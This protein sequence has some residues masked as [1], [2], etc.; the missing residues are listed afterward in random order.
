MRIIVFTC[1]YP[2]RMNPRA[3]RVEKFVKLN[4]KEYDILVVTSK[5]KGFN[6]KGPNVI[7]CG[8]A[9]NLDDTFKSSIKKYKFIRLLHKAFWPDDQLL[10][11]FYFLINY[12]FR[13][14]KKN[15]LILTVSNP[16]SSHMIGWFLKKICRHKWIADIG[17]IYFGNQHHSMLSKWYER[18]ILNSTDHIVVNAEILRNHFLK[19]YP[20]ASEK[21]TVIPNGVHIDA[22]KINKTKSDTIRLSYIGNTYQDIREA[23]QELELLLK[24]ISSNKSHKYQIQLFGRQYFKVIEWCEQLHGLIN[25]SYCKNEEE[26]I[27][28]YSNTD[29]LINFANKN[30]EGLPS[31]LEEYVASGLPIINFQ[32]TEQD[33]SCLFLHSN[34]SIAYY[35]NLNAPDIQAMQTFIELNRDSDPIKK[36]TSSDQAIHSWKSV[37]SK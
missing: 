2:P 36:A 32:Y 24:L 16:F 37:L 12:F 17:D 4:S 6:L 11:Q 10:F 35:C 8:F 33:P 3:F 31:K 25:I 7:R 5:I 19:L 26:L 1:N 29:L 23:V 30:Y 14:R 15:D 22:S 27:Q 9:I 18:K 21:I 13:F 20:L 34:T 28:A